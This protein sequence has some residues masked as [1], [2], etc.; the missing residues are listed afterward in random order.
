MQESGAII[1]ANTLLKEVHDAIVAEPVIADVVR[2]G[3]MDIFRVGPGLLSP[4]E[5]AKRQTDNAFG[6][7]EA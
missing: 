3:V 1:A 2:L 4:S 7:S 6:H 5:L